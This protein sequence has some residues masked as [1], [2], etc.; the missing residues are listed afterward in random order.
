M[1]VYS[2]RLPRKGQAPSPINDIIL[3]T[4]QHRTQAHGLLAIAKRRFVKAYLTQTKV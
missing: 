4:A 3:D 1:T 2:I